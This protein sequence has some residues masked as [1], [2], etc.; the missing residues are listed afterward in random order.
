MWNNLVGANSTIY[1]AATSGYDV[2]QLSMFEELTFRDAATFLRA[3][4]NDINSGQ[5]RATNFLIKGF[6]DWKADSYL[7]TQAIVDAVT[8]TWTFLS[9]EL[10]SN[11]ALYGVG[12]VTDSD[13][14]RD[15]INDLI[16]RAINVI[17]QPAA[18]KVIYP[19]TVEATGQQLSYAGTGVNYNALPFSQRGTGLPPNPRE[20]IV[21]KN[22]GKIFA[23]YATQAGDTYLG[24]DLRVDFE[25]N[26]IEGQ[27]FSRGVQNITLPLIIGIGA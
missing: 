9:D 18:Y 6:F 2:N 27:A 3:I 7:S 16:Q 19:S 4:Q 8:T 12:A 5:D 26:T 11:P 15:L 1:Q 14:V 23:T 22:G 17:S 21:K 24:D 13:D 10:R 20:T 25:R